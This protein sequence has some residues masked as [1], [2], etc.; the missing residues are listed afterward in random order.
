MSKA[1]DT[2]LALNEAEEDKYQVV[3]GTSYHKDTPK[4]V[5]NALERARSSGA[6]VRI[7]LGNQET[8]KSWHEESD[9]TGTLGRSTGPIKVPILLRTGRSSAGS[10]LLDDSIVRLLVDGK[11]VYRHPKY[12]ESEYKIEPVGDKHPD[13]PFSV[14]IDGEEHARFKTKDK[15]QR[16]VDFMSGK[17]KGK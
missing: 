3:N 15:A 17:R 8:G 6:H 9:V 10:A 14:T 1:Q 4:A 12:K 16:W 13:Y 5:V 7:Y 11:E 2:I